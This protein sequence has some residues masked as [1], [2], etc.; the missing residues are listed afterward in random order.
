M[1]KKALLLML[2]LMF[3]STSA[4]SQNIIHGKITGDVQTGISVELYKTSCG[5]DTLV[6]TFTTNSEGY[7]A[8]GC[9]DN[10]DY[11][12]VP[13]YDNS[14]FSP[15]SSNI[16]IPQTIIQSYDF[17]ATILTSC[18]N[19]ATQPCG[20]DVGECQFGIQTCANGQWGVCEGE[21]G[22]STEVCDGI[23]NNCDAVVDENFDL[24]F[25]PNNCGS[26]GNACSVVQACML[27]VCLNQLGEVCSVGSECVTGNCTDNVCCDTT[28]NGECQACN[29]DIQ[30][31]CQIDPQCN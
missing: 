14:T 23:D 24:F 27:G 7:Y 3:I 12:V 31:T 20:S 30:G 11:K 6:G 16:N 9:L 2:V 1:K 4:L 8:F 18:I 22:P 17:T 28:C 5:G 29:L 19:G 13:K 15:E 21:V 25:D 10:S 26:C